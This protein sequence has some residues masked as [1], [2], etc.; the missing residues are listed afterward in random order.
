M[1]NGAVLVVV[2]LVCH[3]GQR[4]FVIITLILFLSLLPGPLFHHIVHKNLILFLQVYGHIP[5]IIPI[6][7]FVQISKGER[8]LLGLVPTLRAQ[9]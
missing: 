2:L 9:F 3:H 5:T 8:Q 1:C 7:G 6:Y 4:L